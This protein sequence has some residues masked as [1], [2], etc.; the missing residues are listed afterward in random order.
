MTHTQIAVIGAGPGGYAA[1]FLAAGRGMQT[2]LIDAEAAPGGVCLHRG[3]IPSKALLH[4]VKLLTETREAEKI[5]LHFAPPRIDLE[6]LRGW[7]EEVVQRLTNGL[8][9]QCRA[10]GVTWLQG[11]ARFL[12]STTLELRRPDQEPQPI[13][14]D[15]AIIA[16]GSRPAAIPGVAMDLPGVM[17][18]SQALRLDAIPASLL[19]IGG[20]NIGLELGTV[21]AAL[22]TRVWVVEA[23][24]GILPGLDRD[25]VRPV[26]ARLGKIMA[27]VTVNARIVALTPNGTGLEV[28]VADGEGR[29]T[30]HEVERVLVAAGREVVSHGLGLENTRVTRNARGE[31]QVSAGM[32]TEDPAILAIGDVT[33]GPM[34]AHRAA[35]QARFAVASL[36]GYPPPHR[37]PIIPAVTYTDPE[38]A[39]AGLLEAEARAKGIETRAVRFPWAA[40]GRAHT[41][42]RTDGVTKLVLDPSS[43]AILGVGITG[44]GA[45]ELIAAAV[46]AMEKGA[47]A[48]DLAHMVHPHPTLSET[49][50]EAADLFLGHCVHYHAP[51][52]GAPPLGNVQRPLVSR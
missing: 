22:G 37:Q 32:M 26:A 12:N 6:R 29:E 16:T 51:A 35:M 40:S 11:T 27:G 1:A 23:G 24:P 34:L 50:A 17:D 38:L 48:Q 49:F 31:I 28:V 36:A 20:G 3:C 10:R 45:G 8:A 44:P 7:K 9:Q 13:T 18:S 14:F 46:V 5:G 19:V 21:Y 15:K 39:W 52:R 4:A 2:T 47:T 43:G 30:T 33:G 41:L 25:L 42:E